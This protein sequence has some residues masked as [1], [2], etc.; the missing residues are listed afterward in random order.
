MRSPKVSHRR[1]LARALHI[2]LV[3]ITNQRSNHCHV[4]LFVRV[5]ISH[6]RHVSRRPRP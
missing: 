2:A 6:T 4:C 3:I 5:C 1:I